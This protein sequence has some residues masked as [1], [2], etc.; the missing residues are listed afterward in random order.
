[1]QTRT[2]GHLIP[3][4]GRALGTSCQEE[5]VGSSR[6]LGIQTLCAGMPGYLEAV[7]APELAHWWNKPVN[8]SFLWAD[9]ILPEE[10]PVSKGVGCPVPGQDCPV[11][12]LWRPLSR[13][14]YSPAPSPSVTIFSRSP[15]PDPDPACSSDLIP[16][17][18]PCH[19][20]LCA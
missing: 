9:L 7:G 20:E 6:A 1:M 12:R 13:A 2:V 4:S 17:C 16:C 3:S 8:E 15:I 18:S 10:D 14:C 5:W 19:R 11:G